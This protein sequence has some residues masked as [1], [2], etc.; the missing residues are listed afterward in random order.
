MTRSWRA[1]YSDRDMMKKTTTLPLGKCLHAVDNYSKPSALSSRS[2]AR[3]GRH[4]FHCDAEQGQNEDPQAPLQRW[5][6]M[7]INISSISISL[8]EE[9][10]TVLGST[11]APTNDGGGLF[12]V[13]LAL[14]RAPPLLLITLREIFIQ[15]PYP[16]QCD[17]RLGVLLLVK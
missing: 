12:S 5:V 11:C 1:E 14:G 8:S 16:T 10:Q 15:R 2:T 13:L 9:R 3:V 7:E 4:V 17:R 6:T